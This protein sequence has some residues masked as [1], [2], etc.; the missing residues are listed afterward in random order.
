MLGRFALGYS[1]FLV[2]GFLILASPALAQTSANWYTAGA[3]FQRTSWVNEQ[4]DTGLSVEWYRVIEPFIDFKSQVIAVDGTLYL[5]TSKGLLALNAATGALLWRYDTELPLGHSPTVVNRVVYIGGY[6]KKMRAL[7]AATGSL[8]WQSTEAQAAFETSP[9]VANN[10]VY[11]GNRDGYL[12]AYS[13]TNGSLSWRYPP[14]G[15]DPLTGSISQAITY[16]QSTPHTLYFAANNMY[17]YAVY[18]DTGTLRWKSTDKLP[19]H[20]FRNYWPIINGDYVTFVSNSPY[21]WIDKTYQPSY[22]PLLYPNGCATGYPN[23]DIGPRF[24]ADGPNDR[25]DISW[26]WPAGSSIMDMSKI[27]TVLSNNPHL[28]THTFLNKNTGAPIVGTTPPYIFWGNN[29]NGAMYPP[30]AMPD[31]S[32]YQRMNYRFWDSGS[33]PTNMG[34][35][36]P[37]T[38]YVRLVDWWGV[39]D[40]PEE[41]SGGGNRLLQ[42]RYAFESKNVIQFANDGPLIYPFN[43]P[44]YDEYLMVGQP[45]DSS[46]WYAGK[47]HS[48]SGIY[49]NGRNNPP[50][51][52]QGRVYFH[53][54][55]ALIAMGPQGESR[56]LD[57]IYLNET[58]QPATVPAAAELQSRLEKEIQK[59]LAV[60]TPGD[61]NRFLL[62]GYYNDGQNLLFQHASYFSNPGETLLTLSMAYAHLPVNS[63]LR[64][65]LLAYLADYYATYFGAGCDSPQTPY[66]DLCVHVGW[67]AGTSRTATIPPP[68]WLD[69]LSTYDSR[70]K[71]GVPRNTW[72]WRYPQFNFYALWQYAQLNPS[73]ALD[74]YTK[75]KPLL[76]FHNLDDPF[77]NTT[78]RERFKE[79]P[80]EIQM[81]MAGYQGFLGLYNLA[82]Q[83]SADQNLAN[84]AQQSLTTYTDFRVQVQTFS[85]DS[86]WFTHTGGPAGGNHFRRRYNIAVNFMW[87]TPAVADL[88]DQNL[89]SQIQAALDEYE[90][91]APYWFAS[92]YQVSYMETAVQPLFDNPALFQAKAWIL[93]QPREELYK[94]LDAPYFERGDLFYIQN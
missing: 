55:N 74:A 66:V 51:F 3:N 80:F 79:Y 72:S 76:E 87:L 77:V 61:A 22:R 27:S 36:L 21:R 30:V 24:T 46:I 59:I 23:C 5:S 73:I 37:G 62:P 75:A 48:L 16:D 17:A 6:D 41:F 92:S 13:A 56:R 58:Y 8:I 19:G 7:N 78:Y 35:W 1:L 85:K 28:Q 94:Y 40:E 44:G 83:P 47:N 10:T 26:P 93:N 45:A 57:N 25:T 71:T 89:H 34:S 82:G 31:G 84:Q 67:E 91:V 65:Q 54:G 49:G 39:V 86:Y 14:S 15:Q 50:I 11:E 52:H 32:L 60:Y 88:L 12:Y 81:Y 63:L 53:E 43:A 38:P 70:T 2:S 69:S 68:Q 29:G 64:P 20:D 9:V 18:A 90:Y 42:Q 33:L 4:V